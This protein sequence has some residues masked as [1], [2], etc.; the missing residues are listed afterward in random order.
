MRGSCFSIIEEI[1][2]I[3]D[4]VDDDDSSKIRANVITNE[5]TF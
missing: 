4:N 1:L 3:A 5:T 2:N